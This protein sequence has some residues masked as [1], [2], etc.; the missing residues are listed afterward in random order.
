ML[1]IKTA[2]GAEL[3]MIWLRSSLR[4]KIVLTKGRVGEMFPTSTRMRKI[5]EI[6]KRKEANRD[7]R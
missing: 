4:K 2:L 6:K 1:F 7:H 5:R 3:A